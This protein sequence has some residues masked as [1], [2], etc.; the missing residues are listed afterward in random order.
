[1]PKARYNMGVSM[2]AKKTNA[3]LVREAVED[4]HSMEQIA[5][6]ETVA[7]Q[8]GLKLSIIDDRLK[9]LVL[10]GQMVRVQR[11]VYVPVT[12]HPEARPIS[13]TLLPDGTVKIDIGD[14][15]LTLT[16]RENR[17]LADLL[18]G[19]VLSSA[20]I[21]VGHQSAQLTGAIHRRL[22]RLESA[23]AAAET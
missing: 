15:V 5:T 18:A 11:G 7:E 20:A 12:R 23:L 9:A 13:K 1:M 22:L 2:T 17:M 16:P 4:L 10:D 19:S 3:D 6:R 21:E 14:D 8:T